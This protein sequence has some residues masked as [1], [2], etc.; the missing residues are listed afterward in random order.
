[1]SLKSR[2]RSCKSVPGVIVGEIDLILSVLKVNPDLRN[3]FYVLLTII[4]VKILSHPFKIERK[5]RYMSVSPVFLSIRLTASPDFM[6][7]QR[8]TSNFLSS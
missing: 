1:M 6:S 3:P 4:S 5:D 2:L 7:N 8:S